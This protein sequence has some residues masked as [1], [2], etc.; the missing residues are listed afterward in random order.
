MSFPG[1]RTLCVAFFQRAAAWP[2][3]VAAARATMNALASMDR[4]ELADIGLTVRPARRLGACARSRSDRAPGASRPRAAPRRPRAA[5]GAARRRVAVARRIVRPFARRRMA[6]VAP[7]PVRTGLAARSV[8][9]GWRDR[10]AEESVRSLSR[11]LVVA[12][13]PLRHLEAAADHP[14]VWAGARHPPAPLRLVVLA[15]RA[16]TGRATRSA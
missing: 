15:V 10:S 11:R 4:R 6:E 9:L 14:G 13:P 7:S 5:D 2:F 1:S 16:S 3:R 8:S 12:E